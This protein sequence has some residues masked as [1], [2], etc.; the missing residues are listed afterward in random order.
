[1]LFRSD[2][3]Y[4]HAVVD[5]DEDVR[6]LDVAVDDALLMRVLNRA[7]NLNEEI[8][9]L[10]SREIALVA[11]I[12]N[13]YAAHQFH[14]KRL[15]KCLKSAR[16]AAAPNRKKAKVVRLARA[17][18]AEATGRQHEPTECRAAELALW[19]G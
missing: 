13:F 7:A 6:R 11:V 18:L 9:P 3:R 12:G 16:P 2:L 14:R 4:R 17:A 8:Q 15:V 1:M 5:G 19:R 10:G